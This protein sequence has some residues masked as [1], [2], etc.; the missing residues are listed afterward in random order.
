M[1]TRGPAAAAAV[2]AETVAG[3]DD[4]VCGCASGRDS[5]PP[6]P[7]FERAKCQLPARPTRLRIS[8]TS[9]SIVT[10]ISIS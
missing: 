1:V 4:L 7:R 9:I 3:N 2:G 5:E 8:P 6:T 10:P